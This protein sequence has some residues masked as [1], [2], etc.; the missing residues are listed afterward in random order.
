MYQ[1]S[2]TIQD[3]IISEKALEGFT[4]T[5]I[6]FL[7]EQSGN[8]VVYFDDDK[9]P[10]LIGVHGNYIERDDIIAATAM[11]KILKIK[12]IITSLL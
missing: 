9:N 2:G 1:M 5:D 4:Y 12:G 3:T 8:P 11:D 6:E 10:Y 7:N